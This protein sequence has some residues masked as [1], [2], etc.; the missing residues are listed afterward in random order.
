MQIVFKDLNSILSIEKILKELSAHRIFLVTGKGSYKLSGAEQF[1][2]SIFSKKEVN[3]FSDFSQ[4]PKLPDI[5]R[6]TE[7]FLKKE[8][9]IIIAV[10]GGSV[11]DTAKL[12][13][14]FAHNSNPYNTIEGS[15]KIYKQG[16]PL[17]AVPTTAGSGSEATH[18]AVTYKDNRKYSLAHKYILPDYSIIDPRL[19][20]SMPPKLTAITGFDALCQSIESF[21]SIFST[22]ESKKYAAKA[23]KMILPTLQNTVCCPTKESRKIMSLASNLAGR[24]INITKTTGAHALSYPLTTYFNIPHGHA[25]AL[26][27]KYFLKINSQ[28]NV[29]S[30]NDPRGKDYLDYLMKELFMLLEC[31]SVVECENKWTELMLSVGLPYRLEDIG[32]NS[33][34]DIDLIL[35]SLN[36]ER[37]NNNPVRIT[38]A[39]LKSVFN[40]H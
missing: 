7:Q 15:S 11:I 2:Y 22:V 32:V 35:N 39:G 33:E 16:L 21:W 19:T 3:Q 24:A 31:R 9:D 25:V 6:G 12:I 38:R 23:I 4:N 30:V 5:I 37:L 14:V 29:F 26:M 18:F 28:P 1:L 34:R 36:M 27:L 8:R 40:I 13:N 17:I 20:Y 10:G